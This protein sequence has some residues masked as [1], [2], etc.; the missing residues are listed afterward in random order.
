MKGCKG[1]ELKNKVAQLNNDAFPL[2]PI[3]DLSAITQ[4][5]GANIHH[6][7]VDLSFFVDTDRMR[8]TGIL[9]FFA[10]KSIAW[11]LDRGGRFE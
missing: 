9:V 5:R 6:H 1:P 10:A 7:H 3:H 4:Q 8:G 2:F 11:A